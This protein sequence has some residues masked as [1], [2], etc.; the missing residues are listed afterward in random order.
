[1]GKVGVLTSERK[2]INDQTKVYANGEV[3]SIGVV[4]YTDGW[5]PFHPIPY[6][7]V[8]DD[9]NIDEDVEGKTVVDDDEDEDDGISDTWI[10]GPNQTED[11]E[12]GEIMPESDRCGNNAG[13]NTLPV[14]I[15]KVGDHETSPSKFVEN[16]DEIIGEDSPKT[17]GIPDNNPG[18]SVNNERTS[19][20]PIF[21]FDAKK[22]IVHVSESSEQGPINKLVSQGCF[23]PFP[24]FQ[25]NN[26]SHV[27]CS[28]EPQLEKAVK[29]RKRNH[30]VTGEPF[31]SLSTPQIP[32][33]SSSNVIP[34]QETHV[35]NLNLNQSPNSKQTSG[36]EGT[37]SSSG[38]EVT[39]TARIGE[40]LG[41]QI[42]GDYIILNAVIGEAGV[43]RN[44]K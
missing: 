23:G 42:D 24:N 9:S 6:D 12:E 40:E 15:S 30:E 37:E 14:G 13:R 22:D 10:G 18:D 33:Y 38:D 5:S 11:M 29:K 26:L 17:V 39:K 36:I 31:L 44:V 7:K 20:L 27:D 16:D 19:P 41:Y 4:E 43:N 2:W 32:L 34:P 25:P 1:M 3:F 35:P 21:K 8:D 28:M